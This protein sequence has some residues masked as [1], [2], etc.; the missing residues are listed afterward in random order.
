M[1]D[2][3]YAECGLELNVQK[4]RVVYCKDDKR[5]Q[6][7]ATLSRSSTSWVI[8]SGLGRRKKRLGILFVNFSPAITNDTVKS[9]RSIIRQWCTDK[10]FEDLSWNAPEYACW[11]DHGSSKNRPNYQRS[12]VGNST[13]SVGCIWKIVENPFYFFFFI[14][15]SM[16]C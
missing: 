14:S 15:A 6:D 13:I 3:R 16:A 12:L 9:I 1:S 2:R 4:A 5:E 10:S 11:E 7:R 8:R